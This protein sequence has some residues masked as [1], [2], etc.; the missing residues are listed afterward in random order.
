MVAAH[1][2]KIGQDLRVDRRPGSSMAD[3]HGD[4]LER[5]HAT[6][7]P[8][9]EHLLE[10]RERPQGGLLD[11]GHRTAGGRPQADRDR[12]R[13]LVVEQ[14]RRQARPRL[15]PVSAHGSP[16][17]MH[18]VTQRPQ[19]IDVVADRPLAHLETVGQL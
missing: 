11:T 7:E 1:A 4:R 13:L 19:P 16:R 2:R 6:A 3:V 9:R 15:E 12:H 14:Q 8:G 10:L 18:R 17:G 5:A